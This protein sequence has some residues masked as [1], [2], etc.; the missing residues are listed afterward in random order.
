[1]PASHSRVDRR[2]RFKYANCGRVFFW[3][4]GENNLRFQ[5]YPDPCGQGH[6]L[7]CA[8]EPMKRKTS[9]HKALGA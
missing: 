1:M 4:T 8:E 3:K 5:K 6:S 9:S 7:I 2:K